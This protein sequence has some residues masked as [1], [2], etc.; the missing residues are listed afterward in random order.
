MTFQKKN[1]KWLFLLITI[2]SI[3]FAYDYANL[4]LAGN[5]TLGKKIVFGIWLITATVWFIIFLREVIIRKKADS[6][7]AG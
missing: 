1:K 3:L 2:S 7:N 6:E 5:C 4:I